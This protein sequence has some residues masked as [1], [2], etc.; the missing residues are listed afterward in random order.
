VHAGNR[1]RGIDRAVVT[2]FA[3]FSRNTSMT[4]A[5]PLSSLR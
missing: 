4:E 3:P 1:L 5:P 2:T